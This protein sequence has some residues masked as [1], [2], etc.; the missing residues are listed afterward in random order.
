MKLWTI[1]P[2]MLIITSIYYYLGYISYWNY[3][4]SSFV[5][6][7]LLVCSLVGILYLGKGVYKKWA[8]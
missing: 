1:I 8:K 4:L 2:A 6:G 5:N 7:N 3:S